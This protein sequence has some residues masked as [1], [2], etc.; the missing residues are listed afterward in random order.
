[1]T[2]TFVQEDGN[3]E[4]WHTIFAEGHPELAK[5]HRLHAMMPSP[6]RCR[7]CLA[8]FGG[9]GGWI[10]RRR[11]KAPSS[12]NPHFCSACDGFLETFPGGAEVTMSLLFVDVRGSTGYAAEASPQEVSARINRF[13][14]HATRTI[15]DH[16]GFIMAFYGDCVVADWPPGFAGP[17][18]AKKALAAARAL[19]HGGTGAVPAGTAVHCGPVYI[20]TVQA[21]KGLFRDVSI[22]GAEVNLTA[23]LAAQARPG[24]ALAT[25]AVLRAAGEDGLD[26]EPFALK[27]FDLPVMAARLS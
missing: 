15:T 4:L 12:R 5:Q 7:L 14:D 6:P 26:T 24:E 19:A 21:A 2:E 11:G 18:H 9:V 13:L 27:D 23:R 17:D 20:S 10:M 3:T 8:P 16:D 25:L 1:M 22:F